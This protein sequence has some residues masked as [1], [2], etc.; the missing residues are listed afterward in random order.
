MTKDEFKQEIL[1]NP[2][3]IY[4]IISS[5]CGII[6]LYVERFKKA[7]QA[8]TVVYSDSVDNLQPSFSLLSQRTLNVLYLQ[9]L[10]EDIFEKD[11]YIFIHV[12]SLDKRSAVYK[13]NK[14]R[15]I[16]VDNDYMPFVMK[17]GLSREQAAEFIKKCN[18]DYGIITHALPIYL[19]GGTVMD[20]SNDIY[21]WVNNFIMGKP[22]PRTTESPISVLALLSSTCQDLLRI[23]NH[24]TTGMNDYLVSKRKEL[25]NYLTK[26]QLQQLISDCFYIDTQIKRGLFDIDFALDYIKGRRKSYGV[27]AT[28]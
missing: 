7:I 17:R 19:E 9:K 5:D 18:N 1:K 3:K 23:M 16:E 14:N 2:Q 8:D 25:L 27:L 20:H 4:C 26:E 21:G 6:D 10:P 13:K 28:V 22:L 15:I 12:D 24:N 11:N